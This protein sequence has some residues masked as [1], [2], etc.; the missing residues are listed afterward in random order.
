MDVC[1]GTN[2]IS[3]IRK[4]KLQCLGHVT[5]MPEERT[6]K[7]EFKI[8]PEEKRSVGKPRKR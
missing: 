2:I 8:I 4:E 6:L 7:K 1:R 5:I 3:K